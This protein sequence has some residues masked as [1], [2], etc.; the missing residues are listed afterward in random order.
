MSI[1]QIIGAL[2]ILGPFGAVVIYVA[3]EWCRDACAEQWGDLAIGLAIPATLIAYLGT[4][5]WLLS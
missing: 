2:M 1:W 3:Y 5:A 4:A